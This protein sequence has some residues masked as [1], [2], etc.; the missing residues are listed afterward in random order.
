M[1]MRDIR[2]DLLERLDTITKER[3]EIRAS[4]KKRLSELDQIEAGN[5]LLRGRNTL[6]EPPPGTGIAMPMTAI[7][8]RWHASL[9]RI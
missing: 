5:A 8:P 9:W 1:S 4:V 7:E 2:A 6:S 3:T